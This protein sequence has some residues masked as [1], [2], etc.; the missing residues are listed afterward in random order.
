MSGRA[1]HRTGNEAVRRFRTAP[2]EPF[3]FR[4]GMRSRRTSA[5][6]LR[7]RNGS[8]SAGHH[9]RGSYADALIEVQHILIV[10]ADAA[11]GYEATDRAR[12]IRPVDRILAARE[13]Q[14]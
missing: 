6:S 3:T 13:G 11:I 12:P 8:R 10:H 2:G 7:C 5:K 14:G 1:A 9:D 4:W